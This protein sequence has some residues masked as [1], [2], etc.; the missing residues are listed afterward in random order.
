MGA[1][2]PNVTVNDAVEPSATVLVD[3]MRNVLVDAP[4]VAV[5]VPTVPIE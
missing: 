5:T 2:C 1:A 4:T 3:S